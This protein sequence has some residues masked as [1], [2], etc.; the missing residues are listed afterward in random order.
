MFR[1]LVTALTLATLALPASASLVQVTDPGQL[2]ATTTANFTDP[3]GA[4]YVFGQPVPNTAGDQIAFRAGGESLRRVDQGNGFSGTFPITTP[5]LF[6]PSVFGPG[7]VPV[8][9]GG[10]ITFTFAVPVTT[11]GVL[12]QTELTGLEQYTLTAFSGTTELATFTVDLDSTVNATDPAFLGFRLVG[13]G[14]AVDRVV[15]ST[16]LG[17]S[18]AIAAPSFTLIPSPATLGVLMLAA[19]PFARRRR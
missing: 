11:F 19:T 14:P 5:L 18:F 2:N 6:A 8:T 4:V 12:A 17:N 7:G 13:S 16:S 1:N 9:E 3:V 10:P 15:L